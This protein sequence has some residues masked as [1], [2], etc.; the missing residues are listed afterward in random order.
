ML[1]QCWKM[2]KEGRMSE[3]GFHSRIVVVILVF[4]HFFLYFIVVQLSKTEIALHSSPSGKEAF[5]LIGECLQKALLEH[6]LSHFS[7]TGLVKA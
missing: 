5:L 4:K 7:L 1:H 2:K 3:C 6:M